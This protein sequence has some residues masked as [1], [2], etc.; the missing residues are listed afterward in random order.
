MMPARP[1]QALVLLPV[2][3]LL[4]GAANHAW[5]VHRHQLSPWLGGGFGMFATND[6]GSFRRVI[7]T[8]IVRDGQAYPVTLREPLQDL[9]DR[10]RGLPDTRRLRA[11]AEAVRAALG[12]PGS[13]VDPADLAALRVEVWRTRLVPK[14]LRPLQTPIV[15]RRFD[16]D[17]GRG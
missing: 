4:T 14:G 10:A 12:E 16:L 15:S 17:A 8:V 6:V 13:G 9:V 3:A 11:L 5:L 2:L 1:R 7:V